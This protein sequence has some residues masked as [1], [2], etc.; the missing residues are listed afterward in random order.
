VTTKRATSPPIC[1]KATVDLD[2]PEAAEE[3]L[4]ENLVLSQDMTE[5]FPFSFQSGC[6]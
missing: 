1:W 3:F 2:D 6:S 5:T 4:D